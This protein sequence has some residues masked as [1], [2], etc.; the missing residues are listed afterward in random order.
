MIS[1]SFHAL[2]QCRKTNINFEFLVHFS[3]RENQFDKNQLTLN[4]TVQAILSDITSF[5]T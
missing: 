5:C 1:Y 4:D 2:V 3:T